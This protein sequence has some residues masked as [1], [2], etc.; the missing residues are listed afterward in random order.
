MF[1]SMRTHVPKSANWELLSISNY[2]GR[3][4]KCCA[5]ISLFCFVFWF[6]G[7]FFSFYLKDCCKQEALTL[8]GSLLMCF[9]PCKCSLASQRT[10]SGKVQL[11]PTS[12]KGLL[13]LQGILDFHLALL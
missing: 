7:V 9:E 11:S 5:S 3:L 12:A 8:V 2:L 6:L 13:S 1:L 4:E 10:S